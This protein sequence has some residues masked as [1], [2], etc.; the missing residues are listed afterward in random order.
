ME[1]SS[2]RYHELRARQNDEDNSAERLSN[3][4]EDNQSLWSKGKDRSEHVWAIAHEHEYGPAVPNSGANEAPS[5]FE[6]GRYKRFRRLVPIATDDYNSLT[7]LSSK[8]RSDAKAE[9]PVLGSQDEEYPSLD[10]DGSSAH[11]SIPSEGQIY[12]VENEIQFPPP[13]HPNLAPA[14][15]PVQPISQGIYGPDSFAESL[16]GSAVGQSQHE[17]ER[18]KNRRRAYLTKWKKWLFVLMAIVVVIVVVLVV[19]KNSS[20][21]PGGDEVYL[22]EGHGAHDNDG[23]QEVKTKSIGTTKPTLTTKGATTVAT[24]VV[25]CFCRTRH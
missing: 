9:A 21:C 6:Q 2:A 10:V 16:Q 19:L 3:E 1:I 4:R 24:T 5:A 12:M 7:L 17:Q 13:A 22:E 11:A 18:V 8:G 15:V 23:K 14:L 20:G 25:R